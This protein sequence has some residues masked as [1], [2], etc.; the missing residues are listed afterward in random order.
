MYGA[1]QGRTGLEPVGGMYLMKSR[2]HAWVLKTPH[3][4]HS[5]ECCGRCHHVFGMMRGWLPVLIRPE[6]DSP[7]PSFNAVIACTNRKLCCLA[8]VDDQVIASH[9]V[10]LERTLGPGAWRAAALDGQP[11]GLSALQLEEW[12]ALDAVPP[13]GVLTVQFR[14][15]KA[16]VEAAVRPAAAQLRALLLPNFAS[17]AASDVWRLSLLRVAVAT[18]C[19]DAGCGAEVRHYHH[20]QNRSWCTLANRPGRG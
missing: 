11:L 10:H 17:D 18:F 13:R 3:L 1:G 6:A 20:T 16:A 4:I 8:D 15:P 2:G 7:C 9:L 14:L 5:H 12:Q 19:I